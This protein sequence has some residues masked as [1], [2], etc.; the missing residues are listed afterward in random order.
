MK[1]VCQIS[2]LFGY[3]Q[4]YFSLLIYLSHKVL[5]F[6]REGVGIRKNDVELQICLQISIKK[7]YKQCTT[8]LKNAYVILGWKIFNIVCA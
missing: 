4:A 3:Y 5:L 8:V 7:Q 2:F 6:K 1:S